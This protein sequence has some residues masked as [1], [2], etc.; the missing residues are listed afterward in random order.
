MLKKTVNQW[1]TNVEGPRGKELEDV[2]EMVFPDSETLE[3]TLVSS[4]SP[5]PVSG[6]R[7]VVS[8]GTVSQEASQAS[9]PILLKQKRVAATVECRGVRVWWCTHRGV[10]MF[11]AS[12]RFT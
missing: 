10:R 3:P 9:I 11:D 6:E 8:R 2:V 7:N 12:W 4:L 1:R 5:A